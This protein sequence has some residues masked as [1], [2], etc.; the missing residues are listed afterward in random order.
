MAEELVSLISPRNC[1]KYVDGH[2]KYE[3]GHS[4]PFLGKCNWHCDSCSLEVDFLGKIYWYEEKTGAA[5]T[6]PER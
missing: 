3:R 6:V 5:I 4:S 2:H 1:I